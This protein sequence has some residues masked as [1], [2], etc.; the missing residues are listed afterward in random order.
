MTL[1]GMKVHE[2]RRA[3]EQFQ[4]KFKPTVYFK[5]I[6]THWTVQLFGTGEKQ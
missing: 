4:G 3:H 5:T 2:K 1:K 6:N